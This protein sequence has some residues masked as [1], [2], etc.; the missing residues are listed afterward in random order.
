MVERR[1][2]NAGVGGSIPP[3]GAAGHTGRRQYRRG[4]V[5]ATVRTFQGLVHAMTVHGQAP[6][7]TVY[8]QVRAN[9]PTGTKTP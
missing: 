7:M 3:P 1:A 8:G 2:E 5:R 4:Y 6:A 9:I